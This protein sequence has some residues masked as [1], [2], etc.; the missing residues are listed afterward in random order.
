MAPER[1][2]MY[3]TG[4]AAPAPRL[5]EGESAGREAAGTFA[6]AP[7]CVCTC[8]AEPEAAPGGQAEVRIFTGPAL[9][10]LHTIAAKGLAQVDDQLSLYK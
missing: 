7:A 5:A 2:K 10:K 6:F 9:V 3:C 4:A 8:S 1:H